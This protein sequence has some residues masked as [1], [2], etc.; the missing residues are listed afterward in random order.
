MPKA[1]RKAGSAGQRVPGRKTMTL[2][3]TGSEWEMLEELAKDQ[4]MSKMAIM[5]TALR[6]YDRVSKDTKAGCK[7]YL[8]NEATKQKTELYVIRAD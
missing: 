7:F 6:L 2:N 1:K 4:G 3:L 8:E 5:R